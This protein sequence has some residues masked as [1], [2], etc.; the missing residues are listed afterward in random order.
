V[1]AERGRVDSRYSLV[2]WRFTSFFLRMHTASSAINN[3][4]SFFASTKNSNYVELK[5][6]NMFTRGNFDHDVGSN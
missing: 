4:N 2:P 1:G 3:S 6:T 5:A